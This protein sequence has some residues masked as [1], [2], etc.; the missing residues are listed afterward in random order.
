MRK[1]IYELKAFLIN[2]SEMSS[3]YSY[4]FNDAYAF[5]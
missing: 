1:E 2:V 5:L 4:S 3:Y